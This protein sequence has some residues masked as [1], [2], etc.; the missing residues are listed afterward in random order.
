VSL[1][2][3][4][5]FVQQGAAYINSVLQPGNSKSVIMEASA[6]GYNWSALFDA[7]IGIGD[8]RYGMSGK[9]FE[10]YLRMGFDA[11]KIAEDIIRKFHV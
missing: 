2:D 9:G 4:S 7:Q 3:F 11:E 1:P 5:K 6:M 10:V 8:L